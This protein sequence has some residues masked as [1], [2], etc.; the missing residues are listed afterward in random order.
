M[1][2]IVCK[3]KGHKLTSIKK[4]NLLIKEYECTNCSQKFTTDGYGQIV[5]LNR[6]WQE[7]NMLFE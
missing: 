2:K 7:N 6:Y 4:N 3:V 5:I 1:K